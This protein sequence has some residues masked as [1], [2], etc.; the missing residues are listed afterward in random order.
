MW[1][2]ITL[3][4][5]FFLAMVLVLDKFILTKSVG[6]PVVYAFY[7]T[8]FLLLGFLAWPFGVRVPEG[9][10][11]FWS[12]VSGAGFGAGMWTLYI[13]VKTG[14]ASHVN[15]FIGSVITVCTFALS[16]LLLGEA[17]SRQQ[18]IGVM[19]LVFSS[20]LLAFEKSK[21]H[22]GF[23]NGFLWGIL[24]GILF[25]VSHVT[26]KH[27][28]DGYDFLTGLVWSRGSAG[29]FGMAL[30]LVPAVRHAIANALHRRD[31]LKTYA[32]RHARAIVAA[33]KFLSV[34]GIILVHYGIAIGSVT[35][36]NALAG[37]EFVFMF[38]IIF[39]LTR[40]F[41]RVLK[42]YFT[43]QELALELTAMA[44][45]ALGSVLVVL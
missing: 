41:P 4:G 10:D 29:F 9:V 42:E 1:F 7:S 6:K 24:S 19:I 13:A 22:N 11:F 34:A 23:H 43:R 16:S 3:L 17:L 18:V 35:L 21:K 5:Y 33:N 2:F 30:L 40:C 45:V 39:F 32:H 28:Y 37:V 15:P 25:S 27:L 26:A 44:L 12:L 31:P 36:V 8:I 20:F 38:M 14:E